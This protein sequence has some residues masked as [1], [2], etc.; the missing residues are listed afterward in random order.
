MMLIEN[1]QREDLEPLE[2]SRGMVE[3]RE[4]FG[5][6]E[7]QI[8]RTIGK[9]P[10]FVRDRLA[11]LDLPTEIREKVEK[12]LL[13]VSQAILI[14]DL[15]GKEKLQLEVARA[16]EERKLSSEVVGRMVEEILQPKRRRKK[17]KRKHHL[18]RQGDPL[19]AEHMQRK[20]QQTVLRGEDLLNLLDGLP[21]QRWNQQETE[22]LIGV[23]NAIDEGLQRFK[24]RAV[25]RSREEK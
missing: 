22:K 23:V 11:L 17:M 2:E 9:R 15:H 7:D 14:A 24:R 20:L 3:L 10:Q 1:M 18:K 8:A 16:A 19:S 6:D 21:L 5:F 25:R 12:G 4:R 13:G